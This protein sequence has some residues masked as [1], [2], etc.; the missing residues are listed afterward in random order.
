M[1]LTY[2]Y[3]L[4]MHMERTPY[5]WNQKKEKKISKV[6]MYLMVKFWY[7]VGPNLLHGNQTN[8]EK[9]SRCSIDFRIVHPDNFKTSDKGSVTANVKFK[10]G[11]YFE[12]L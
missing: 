12:K 6:T 7:L 9:D 8:I 2:G 4:L 10:V 5:G 3:H 1:R 11:G